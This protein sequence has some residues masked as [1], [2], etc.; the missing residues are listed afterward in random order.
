MLSM[1]ITTEEEYG[2]AHWVMGCDVCLVSIRGMVSCSSGVKT[3]HSWQKW[4]FFFRKI[5]SYV[6]WGTRIGFYKVW[7]SDGCGHCDDVLAAGLMLCGLTAKMVSWRLMLSGSWNW[8][9]YPGH[10]GADKEAPRTCTYFSQSV[11]S[12]G[13]G[14]SYYIFCGSYVNGQFDMMMFVKCVYVSRLTD[15]D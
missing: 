11:D 9:N 8:M 14:R 1:S 6:S 13:S 3:L 5:G 2:V 4:P 15:G 10:T 7:N 12:L